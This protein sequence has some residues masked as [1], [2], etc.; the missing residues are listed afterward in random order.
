MRT[1]LLA[2]VVA[3]LL[4]TLTPPPAHATF[5]LMQ[6]EQVIGGVSGDTSA[7]AIQLRMRL[8]GQGGVSKARLVVREPAA[9]RYAPG[10]RLAAL[11]RNVM[12][13]ASVRAERRAILAALERA[14]A[15]FLATRDA[16][17][18]DSTPSLAPHPSTAALREPEGPR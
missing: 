12:L 11:G 13:N 10:P 17:E 14:K 16:P 15:D 5:H 4:L 3:A 2:L 7:Q 1:R 8:D 18:A 6:V 9:R